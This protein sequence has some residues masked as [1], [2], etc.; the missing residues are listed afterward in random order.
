M[1]LEGGGEN[2]AMK[3]SRI[4]LLF[5]IIQLLVFTTVC[6]AA[7]EATDAV[8]NNT[9]C[10]VCGMFVAKYPNWLARIHYDDLGQTKFFDGVKDMMAF[11]FSPEK[12][13]SASRES[14]SAIFVKDYYSLNWL[15]AK[16]AFY[17]VGSDV[18]GPMGHELI[19][20]AT[21]EAAESFSKD[22]HGKEILTF[23]AIT[24]ELIESLR[25]GQRMQ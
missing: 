20:F 2:N 13:G 8:S 16:E 6:F 15:S 9:R 11:Y 4:L 5:I 25:L 23:G 19:P 10:T 22:H 14:I 24:P 17:V 1:N 21:R 7:G 3:T 12:Y 18:Y